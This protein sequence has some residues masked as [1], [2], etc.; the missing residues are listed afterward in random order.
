MIILLL[1]A[2]IQLYV[3]TGILC[4]DFVP[5]TFWVHAARRVV[6]LSGLRK[7]C[8]NFSVCRVALTFI[9]RNPFRT[10]V[11]AG[12]NRVAARYALTRPRIGQKPSIQVRHR[13]TTTD[14]YPSK[15]PRRKLLAKTI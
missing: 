5:G 1:W 4:R 15:M 13:P 2:K 14:G 11:R 10:F 7:G 8:A 6:R 12:G 9:T 3:S